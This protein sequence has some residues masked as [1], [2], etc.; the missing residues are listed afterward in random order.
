MR[1]DGGRTSVPSFLRVGN[2]S[3]IGKSRELDKL[4]KRESFQED[5]LGNQNQINKLARGDNVA[6]V[7]LV[8]CMVSP[9]PKLGQTQALTHGTNKSYP[10]THSR[11]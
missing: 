2:H 7:F 1:W 4:T 5:V 3:R 6:N 9:T 8:A 10:V 11:L